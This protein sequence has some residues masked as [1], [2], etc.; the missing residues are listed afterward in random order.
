MLVYRSS[1]AFQ[2]ESSHLRVGLRVYC[3]L[4]F[5]VLAFVGDRCC[6]NRA[7]IRLSQK[8]SL[9]I[10]MMTGWLNAISAVRMW[11]AQKRLPA[12]FFGIVMIAAELMD[13]GSDLLVS[14]LVKPIQIPSRCP[15]GQGIVLTATPVNYTSIPGFWGLGYQMVSQ[16]QSNSEKNNGL[17]GLYEKINQDPNFRAESQDV[18]GHWDCVDIQHDVIYDWN[19]T[20]AEVTADLQSKGYLYNNTTRQ[21]TGGYADGTWNGYFAWGCSVPQTEYQ[22]WDMRASLSVEKQSQYDRKLIRSYRC[23]LNAPLYEWVVGRIE[24]KIALDQWVFLTYGLFELEP[25]RPVTEILSSVLESMT[26]IGWQPPLDS[27]PTGDPTQGCI[28]AHAEIPWPLFTFLALATLSFLALIIYWVTSSVRLRRLQSSSSSSKQ[29]SKYIRAETPNGLLGWMI[30]A[31]REHIYHSN[32][33]INAQDIL[34]LELGPNDRELLELS[35]GTPPKSSPGA[36]MR[37]GEVP[38]ENPGSEP[39]REP[40]TQVTRETQIEGESAR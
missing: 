24:G 36:P 20:Q 9:P 3:T 22:P 27:K 18:V 21:L 7:M 10:S 6:A 33:P 35:D 16:A 8:S 34:R 26:M 17:L 14:G 4:L 11:I 30:Q 40:E 13:I 5:L 1:L 38:G 25:D 39:R 32:Q 28:I 37:P 29:Y 15:F 19:L 2:V 31:G 12:G 23:V